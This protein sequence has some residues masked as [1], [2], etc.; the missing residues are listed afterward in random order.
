MTSWNRSPFVLGL[1]AG[2]GALAGWAMLKAI[3]HVADVLLLVVLALFFAI[4]LEPVV[5]WIVARGMRR[6]VAVALVT[7]GLAAALAGFVAAV[8]PPVVTEVRAVVDAAPRWLTELHDHHSWLGRLEDKYHVIEQAKK[9]LTVDNVESVGVNG[10]LGAGKILASALSGTIVVVALTLYFLG[11]LPEIK[12]FGYRLVPASRRDRARA[13]TEQIL[14]QVGR[15]ML[16]NIFTSVLAGA[17]TTLWCLIWGIPFAVALGVLV[18]ILDLIPMIG[19]TIGGAIVTLVGLTQS[20]LVAIVTLVFY[21]G[22]RL[23]EDYLLMPRVN[24][25]TVEVDPV[26]TV[27]ALA[28]GGVLL[29]ITGALLAVPVAAALRVLYREVLQPEVDAR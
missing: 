20:F 19:S 23:A 25:H 29:G 3:A 15:Y 9:R 11:G 7:L 13:V 16:G 28:L 6:G 12:R 22:F 17:A 14:D 18:A 21:I 26:V 5:D 27:V 24:R 1:L 10:L 8:V 4:S 2:L